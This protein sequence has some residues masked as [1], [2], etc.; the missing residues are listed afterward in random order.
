[1]FV[2]GD[3]VGVDALKAGFRVEGSLTVAGVENVGCDGG[4][5]R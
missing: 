4:F 1:V 3:G 2:S 5:V